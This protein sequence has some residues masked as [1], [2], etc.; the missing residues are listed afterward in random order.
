MGKNTYK[1]SFREKWNTFTIKLEQGLE[2]LWH[3][4]IRLGKFVAV[5]LSLLYMLV[6]PVVY[7]WMCAEPIPTEIIEVNAIVTD[8]HYEAP[9]SIPVPIYMGTFSTVTTVSHPE[10]Y[11][12]TVT[13]NNIT[14]TFNN[15][16]LYNAVKVGDYVT[17]IY[18]EASNTLVLGVE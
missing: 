8:V 4:L 11:D 3:S 17:V 13:Y 9:Y 18:Q 10:R 16:D 14:E 15:K 6:S 7:Y 12:V 1:L 2:A 5:I